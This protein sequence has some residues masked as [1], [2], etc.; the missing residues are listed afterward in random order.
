MAPQIIEKISTPLRNEIPFCIKYSMNKVDSKFLQNYCYATTH[1]IPKW[2]IFEKSQITQVCK[3]DTII[4]LRESK[5]TFS[6][7]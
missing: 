4:S 1:A 7:H 6:N 3:N 5:I 2:V